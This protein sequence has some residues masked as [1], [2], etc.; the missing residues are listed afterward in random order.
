M[1]ALFGDRAS[2]LHE[3]PNGGFSEEQTT[4]LIADNLE[5]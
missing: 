2:T 1:S 5:K 3:L 4:K